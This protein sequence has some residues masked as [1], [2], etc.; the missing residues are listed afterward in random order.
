MANDLSSRA[1]GKEHLCSL[2]QA[3]AKQ[4][5]LIAA[6]SIVRDHLPIFKGDGRTKKI[7]TYIPF[8]R[9]RIFFATQPFW[10]EVLHKKIFEYNLHLIRRGLQGC[11]PL[12]AVAEYDCFASCWDAK[13]AYWGTRPDQYD[14]TFRPVFFFTPPFPGYP[15]G[16]A[17]VSGM[18]AE[19]YSYFFPSENIL[20]KSRKMLQNPASREDSFPYGQ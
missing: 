18:I 6:A 3:K 1:Y 8:D 9:K 20:Q 2:W 5:H 17:M 10:Q 11:M 16:H 12:R 7:Q 13:Y 4:L 15:S 19:L 14:T